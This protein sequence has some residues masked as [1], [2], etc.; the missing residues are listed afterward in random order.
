MEY[1]AGFSSGSRSV[2]SPG[3]RPNQSGFAVIDMARSHHH[4]TRHVCTVRSPPRVRHFVIGYG[5][6]VEEKTPLVDAAE[7][8]PDDK[9][10]EDPP[11]FAPI[12]GCNAPPARD[13]LLG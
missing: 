13:P 12:R 2:S 9:T 8:P 6:H 1:R 11:L 4:E 10:A 5:Q 3:Q 7:S